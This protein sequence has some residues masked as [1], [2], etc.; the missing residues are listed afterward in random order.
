MEQPHTF[1]NYSITRFL[2]SGLILFGFTF[3]FGC[4]SKDKEPPFLLG[5]GAGIS[6]AT[7][8]VKDLAS[9]I[10]YY[11]DTLGFNIRGNGGPGIFDES[12]SVAIGLVDMTSF[13]IMSV[14]DSADKEIVPQFI[15]SFLETNEGVRLFSLVS[16]SVDSAYLSLTA[17]GFQMDSVQ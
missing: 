5:Q 12:V 10:E 15:S 4:E 2:L 8:M 11:K 6:N 7:L 1:R 3:F 14:S 17:Q 16:S 13:E 9:A